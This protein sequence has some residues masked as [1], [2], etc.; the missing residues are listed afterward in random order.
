M[1]MCMTVKNPTFKEWEDHDSYKEFG[2]QHPVY[3][4]AHIIVSCTFHYEE[5]KNA[6]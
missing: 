1:K 3:I 5:G 4:K 2:L 6:W